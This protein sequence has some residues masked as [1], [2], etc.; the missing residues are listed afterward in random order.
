MRPIERRDPAGPVV[1]EALG[2]GEARELGLAPRPTEAS[3]QSASTG[4]TRK[5]RAPFPC[6]RQH[7]QRTSREVP[8]LPRAEV[9]QFQPLEIYSA[10]D[11]SCPPNKNPH[12]RAECRRCATR[13]EASWIFYDARHGS[14]LAMRA[15][16]VAAKQQRRCDGGR[17]AACGILFSRLHYLHAILRHRAGSPYGSNSDAM[18]TPAFALLQ[19]LVRYPKI[20][21]QFRQQS[22]LRFAMADTAAIIAKEADVW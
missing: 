6:I 15:S 20:T 10:S 2:Q 21:M 11:A 8:M 4:T 14:F 17:H 13:C 18:Q 5:R 16:C 22:E 19:R 3:A 9:L 1:H 12:S 7:A